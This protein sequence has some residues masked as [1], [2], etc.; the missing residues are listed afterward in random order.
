M[1]VPRVVIVGAGF[2]GYHA[3]RRVGV[4]PDPL[5]AA[6]GLRT[7]QGRLC[8]DTYLSVPGHPEVY[9]CGDAAAVPDATRPGH[10]TPMTAQHA[11]RQGMRGG[12]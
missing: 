2:A 7:E 1:A 3:A 4:R 8:V 6:T 5:V 10:L 9:A 12:P 11:V